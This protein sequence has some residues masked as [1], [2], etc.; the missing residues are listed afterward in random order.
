[1]AGRGRGGD[2]E[3]PR[4][5]LRPGRRPSR[6]LRDRWTAARAESSLGAAARARESFQVL[7]SLCCAIEP[8][9][10]AASLARGRD[11]TPESRPQTLRRESSG[12]GGF[13]A[14]HT[15]SL[16][17]HVLG[18]EGGKGG[19]LGS[20]GRRKFRLKCCGDS[21]SVIRGKLP[22]RGRQHPACPGS[23]PWCTL[24]PVKNEQ[25]CDQWVTDHQPGGRR[26]LCSHLTLHLETCYPPVTCLP[27]AG[28]TSS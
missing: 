25:V 22:S 6:A 23:G 3:T 26:T 12:S 17:C 5:E 20:K 4:W 10:H 7:G 19:C 13:Q 14:C 28:T 8:W 18:G 21:L 15:S 24:L 27:H 9:G 11:V 1:M 16:P 2:V